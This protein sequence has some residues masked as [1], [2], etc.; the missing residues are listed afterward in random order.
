[1][2]T[3]M[4]R[5]RPR[6]VVLAAIAACLAAALYV[7]IRRGKRGSALSGLGAPDDVGS[8]RATPVP[9]GKCV[10]HLHGK[11]GAGARPRGAGSV[12]HLRPSGNAPGWGGRQWLYFPESGY[13]EVRSLVARAIE[14]SGCGQVIVHGF[15]NGAA[16]AAKLFC[17]TERFRDT[18]VGYIVDDPVP[19]LAVE[20]CRP[21]P[22][23]KLR[24]YWT[25]GLD[26]ATDGWPC[27]SRDWTCEG[28]TTIGIARYTML[29]GTTAA[30]S[31]H[32]KHQEYGAPPEYMSWW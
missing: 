11:S 15:S 32:T 10:V 26:N 7:G 29:L 22:G 18:V 9:G 14:E 2:R 16:A 17:R 4:L 28:G 30:P 24:V 27:S 31:I 12:T 3:L 5:T 6:W 13:Q 20:G 25:G 23:V 1:M 19:D 8:E 21:P